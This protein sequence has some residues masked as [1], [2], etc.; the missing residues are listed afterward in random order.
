MRGRP[1]RASGAQPTDRRGAGSNRLRFDPRLIVRIRGWQVAVLV[2]F[3]VF[4]FVVLVFVALFF[5]IVVIVVIVAVSVVVIVRLFG[6]D[7]VVIIR[8]VIDEV[9]DEIII[10]EHLVN[11]ILIGNLLELHDNGLARREGT[12]RDIG[13]VDGI[14]RPA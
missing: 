3:V 9:V 14:R 2:V 12:S 6:L 5:V 13:R 7:D 4:F 8:D 10:D 11:E 1:T